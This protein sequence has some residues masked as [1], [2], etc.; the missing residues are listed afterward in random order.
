MMPRPSS[1][2]VLALTKRLAAVDSRMP[3]VVDASVVGCH[4]FGAGFGHFE[5][6]AADQRLHRADR[7]GVQRAFVPRDSAA[8]LNA[9][10]VQDR[11]CR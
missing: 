11:S 2:E 4:V 1:R 7:L 8:K 5:R 10:T 9:A 3:Q 6:A